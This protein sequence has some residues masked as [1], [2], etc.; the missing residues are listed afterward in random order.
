MEKET[1]AALVLQFIKTLAPADILQL[2]QTYGSCKAALA[3]DVGSL[4]EG[5]SQ[6]AYSGLNAYQKNPE[7]LDQ[8]AQGMFD[9]C[10]DND[11]QLLPISSDG[12]PQLLKEISRPPSLL[13]VKGDIE[14]LRFPQIAI[15]G[16]RN[17]TAGGLKN[18]ADFAKLL[19]VNGFVVTSG[20][21]LGIDGAA[22]QG[23][24]AGGKTLAVIGAGIDVI[25]PRR[26][27]QLYQQVLDN[28]GAIVSEFLPGTPPL[29]Q[30][31]PR[32]NRLISG[33]SLGVLVVEAAIKS[34]SLITARYAMEQGREVF[35]L[36]GSIHNA[37]SKGCHLLLKQ[38]ATLVETASDIVEQLGGMLSYLK[39]ESLEKLPD[40]HSLLTEPQQQLLQVMGFDPIDMDSLLART[41]LPVAVLS[42]QLVALEL[43]GVVENRAGHFIRIY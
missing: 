9:W 25:Y 24:M 7:L 37:V 26:H 35:A 33:L 8:K 32:R 4:P 18:A 20:L 27:Q 22:H 41:E 28:G 15:V 29:P 42:Q 40:E 5:F 13:F 11:V 36:P 34:G 21:A 14:L 3:A 31:F 12:Y 19:A 6:Q 17:A 2:Y 43:A 30:N 10:A 1:L 39:E 16:S 38:G 23:A